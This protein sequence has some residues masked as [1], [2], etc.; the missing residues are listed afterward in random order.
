MLPLKWWLSIWIAE[1]RW[2]SFLSIAIFNITMKD[3][4]YIFD[5]SKY[6]RLSV[7]GSLVYFSIYVIKN[8]YSKSRWAMSSEPQIWTV[9]WQ[10]LGWWWLWNTNKMS[11][12][13]KR[14][15]LTWK[16]YLRNVYRVILTQFI[17]TNTMNHSI[18]ESTFSIQFDSRNVT[19]TLK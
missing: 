5:R 19:V 4:I 7:S 2:Q 12:Q 1:V 9:T 16:T 6:Y 18:S 14:N 10:R 3:N 11:I 17:F 15:N 8:R 13:G